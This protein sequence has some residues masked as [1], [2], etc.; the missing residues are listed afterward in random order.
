M[1]NGGKMDILSGIL[2]TIGIV[3]KLPK[4]ITRQQSLINDGSEVF[5]YENP[6]IAAGT[7]LTVS[8][9]KEFPKSR[10]W[11]PLDSFEII[12]NSAENINFYLNPKDKYT[13]IAYMIKPI[14][15][16]PITTFILE[17]LGSSAI[18]AGEIVIHMRRLSPDIQPVVSTG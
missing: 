13:V 5:R 4:K 9:E 7:K 12:N 14:A 2:S 6:E 18:A 3:E 10:L 15:R 16:Q 1:L 17:N 8:I 11:L